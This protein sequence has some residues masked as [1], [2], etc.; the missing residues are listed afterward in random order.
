M[1]ECGSGI[2]PM[3]SRMTAHRYIQIYFVEEGRNLADIGIE[4]IQGVKENSVIVIDFCCGIMKGHIL[5]R[6]PLV[7]FNN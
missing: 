1:G 3:H 2:A 5:E 4:C 7:S 6:P